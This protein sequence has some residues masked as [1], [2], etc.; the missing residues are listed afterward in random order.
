MNTKKMALIAGGGIIAV[1]AIGVITLKIMFPPERLK[2]MVLEQLQREIDRQVNIADVNLS[3]VGG[4][5]VEVSG[6]TVADRP[7]FAA[8]GKDFLTLD[9]FM[10][11]IRFWPLLERRIVVDKFTL[12][13]PRIKVHI[14][15]NG[16]ANYA[17]LA[18]ADTA[19][20]AAPAQGETA[21]PLSVQASAISIENGSVH[22]Q[23]DQ[24]GL[25]VD[26][27]DMDYTTALSVASGSRIE[28]DG[29]LGLNDIRIQR[30]EGPVGGIAARLDHRVTIDA[31]QHTIAVDLLNLTLQQMG[32]SLK[33]QI[34]RYDA[35]TAYVDLT[36]ASSDITIEKIIAS[37]PPDVAVRLAGAT[38]AGKIAIEGAVR[39]PAAPGLS[40]DITATLTLRDGRLE[41][42]DVPVPFTAIAADVTVNNATA[43][44]RRLSLKAGQSDIALSG[45]VSP[46]YGG[47]P[48]AKPV[49]RIDI[50]SNFLNIDE[51]SP[52]VTDPARAVPY[53][54]LPDVVM[55]GAANIKK[56][57]VSNLDLTDVQ[58]NIAMQNQVVQLTDIAATAYGGHISG[59][60]VQDLTDV[61]HPKVTLDTR[62]A[63]VDVAEILSP[64]LPVK[65][66]LSGKISTSFAA[67]T[68]LDSIGNP[69]LNLLTALGSLSIDGGRVTNWAPLRKLSTHLKVPDVEKVDFRSL[70]GAFN[71]D[72]GRVRTQGLQLTGG[73]TE[74]LVAGS[75]GLDGSLDYQMKILFSQE[76]TAKVGAGLAGHALSFFK[77]PQ[78]RAGVTLKVG[79][80]FK[81]PKF[82]WDSGALKQQVTAKLT[83]EAQKLLIDQQ[84]KLLGNAL[85]KTT[86]TD[87]LKTQA[88]ALIKSGTDSLKAEL[89]A[90]AKGVLKGLFKRE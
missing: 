89:G 31:E 36:V 38:G 73:P 55:R 6:L 44:I 45:A 65:N 24:G 66:L 2:T 35:D 75:A 52:P 33:G 59:T 80:T 22:Y 10:L 50:A 21:E 87:S 49:A 16:V 9:R 5:G 70:A 17:D 4:L 30:P 37:L 26:I 18:R 11:H 76:L 39:G 29:Q 78:G 47:G 20:A 81:D 74:W 32:V 57:R 19:A 27:G 25:E 40:P 42:P 1:L 46:L 12:T 51:I 83:Q 8:S 28:A 72:G 53:K 62:I 13:G 68:T 14:D 3:V 82:S 58:A 64:V 79:G 69:A 23:D 43:V 86:N 34:A 77:D 7:A 61:K 15:E 90:K 48:G 67:N 88:D 85:I 56:A 54:P 84:Q 41:T 71:I 63:S 60:V